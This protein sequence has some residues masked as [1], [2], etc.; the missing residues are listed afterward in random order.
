MDNLIKNKK[1]VLIQVWCRA[2]AS[3]FLTSSQG[4]LNIDGPPT[5]SAKELRELTSFF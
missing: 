4:M 3:A 1:Q 5:S 2:W